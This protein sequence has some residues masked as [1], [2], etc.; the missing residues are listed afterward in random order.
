MCLLFET[1]KIVAGLPYHLEWHEK[2]MNHSIRTLWP[3][4]PESAI[5]P[6]L[7][8]PKEFD[9]GWVKCKILYDTK[10]RKITFDPYHKNSLATFKLVC[11]DEIDYGLKYTDRGN[12]ASLFSQRGNCDDVIIVRKGK[13]TDTSMA[14]LLFF[15]GNGWFTPDE[16]LLNGTCR[17]RLLSEGKIRERAIRP[18]DLHQYTGFKII[19][20]MRNPEGENL[21]SIADISF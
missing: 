18:E 2:R 13:I 17:A 21:L 14:N 5:I 3:G 20:A 8:I 19:N 1:V 16:P 7:I 15:D 4:S 11:S 9:K 6:G 10:I 12:I